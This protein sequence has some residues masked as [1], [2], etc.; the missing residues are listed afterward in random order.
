MKEQKYLL[1]HRENGTRLPTNLSIMTESE[2]CE[3]MVKNREK[4]MSYNAW[5][6]GESFIPELNIKVVVKT[7]EEKALEL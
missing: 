7:E 6:L 1:Q 5:V 4:D 2:L 3:F